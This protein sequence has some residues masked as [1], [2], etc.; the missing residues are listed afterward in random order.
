MPGPNSP[1]TQLDADQVLR[2]VY[3]EATDKLRVDTTATIVAGA[4][5]VLID[6]VDD[7]VLIVGTEDGNKNGTQHAVK[8][9]SDRNLNVKD[10]ASNASLASIDGKLPDLTTTPV[11]TIQVFT[12]AFDTIT[13]TYPSG[14]QEVYQSRIG[15][16]AGAVQETVTVNYTDSTKNFIT[17]L[18]RT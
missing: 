15:G 16:L 14:T 4:M 12:K 11:K 17:N 1:Y 9:T 3:D 13:A 2:Q 18:V 5:E 6:S 8:V 7:S 10:T